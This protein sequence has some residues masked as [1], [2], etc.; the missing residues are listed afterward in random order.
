MQNDWR[1]LVAS[2]L[3]AIPSFD[4]GSVLNDVF[5]R[6]ADCVK[7]V[8][9]VGELIVLE[10]SM[11]SGVVKDAV[12]PD[13]DGWTV[14]V[15][16]SVLTGLDQGAT[17]CPT[18]FD[19]GVNPNRLFGIRLKASALAPEGPML[20]GI[21]PTN[22]DEPWDCVGRISTFVGGSGQRFQV[23]DTG[24]ITHPGFS[25]CVLC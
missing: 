17:P 7:L 11:E 9:D 14:A 4:L 10:T 24:G 5:F 1:A 15:V 19:V 25:K 13:N 23:R 6:Q 20:K 12:V 8:V 3:L 2:P 21:T 22:V 16:G 18:I